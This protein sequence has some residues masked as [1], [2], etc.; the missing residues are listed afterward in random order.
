MNI[1]FT[2]FTPFFLSGLTATCFCL[3]VREGEILTVE[4]EGRLY[5]EVV[6]AW[7][8]SEG[9]VTDLAP[10]VEELRREGA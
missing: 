2:V 3:L 6:A 7:G 10:E 4:E 8:L 1:S 9:L 5:E